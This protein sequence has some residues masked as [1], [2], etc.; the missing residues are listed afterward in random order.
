MEGRNGMEESQKILKLAVSIGELMLKSGGEIYRVQDTM[1]LILQAYGI[2]DYHVFV[3]SNGIFATIHEERSDRGSM[4]RYVPLGSVHL[5]RITELNQLSRE[6]C[7]GRLGLA[8]AYERLSYCKSLPSAGKWTMLW[9]SGMGCAGFGYIYGCRWQECMLAFVLGMAL[10]WFL[11]VAARAKLSKFIVNIIGSGL[12]SVVSFG[13]AALGLVF[14]QD[15]VVI[16]TIF[17]LVPGVSLTTSI[18]ELFNG[19]YLSG[20][21][22]LADALMTAACIAVGVG[23]AVRIFQMFGGAGL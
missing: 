23:A 16:G 22:H 14:M 4:V 20:S 1:G 21:I 10:Q 7:E 15:K 8:D 17:L 11:M 9:A 6:I 2:E 18:R 12:V 3:V 13:L 19:D 5:Q